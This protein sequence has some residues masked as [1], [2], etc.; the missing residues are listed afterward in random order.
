MSERVT[1]RVARPDDL[2]A[3]AGLCVELGY[4]CTDEEVRPRLAELLGRDDHA[5]F[6]AESETSGVIGWVHVYL[7]PLL[8]RELQSEIGG[9][10]TG[11]AYRGLGAGRLLTER[12]EAWTRQH[13]G[14]AVSLRSNVVREGAHEFYR[15]LGYE[16]VKTSHTFRK[17]VDSG[18]PAP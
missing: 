15:R 3:V 10:V 2:E 1:I 18:A 8:E 9:L 14:R 16:R 17:P 11:E 4:D 13:G 6:V 12:A 7:S 5:V